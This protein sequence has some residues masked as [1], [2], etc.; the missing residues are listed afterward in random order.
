MP[1]AFL[2]KGLTLKGTNADMRVVQAHQHGRARWRGFVITHQLLARLNQAK[3]FGGIHSQG[4]E[5]GCGQQLAH[6][7]FEC[8]APVA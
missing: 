6:A 5:H 8:E 2:F 7:A 3:G 4:L 1:V